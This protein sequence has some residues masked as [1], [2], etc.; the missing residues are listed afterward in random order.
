MHVQHSHAAVNDTHAVIAK[1]VS[2]G[3][4]AACID[5]SELCGL[6]V[7]IRIIHDFSNV[8]HIFC[9]G[10]VGTGLSS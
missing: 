6:E 8:R 5:S 9:A 2:N 1:N 3:S 10:V 4:A 7:H